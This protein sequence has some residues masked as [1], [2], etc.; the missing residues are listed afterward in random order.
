MS[1][2][3]DVLRQ[4][5]AL[6]AEDRAYVVTVLGR[7]LSS[8]DE[9]FNNDTD[10]PEDSVSG[11]AFLAELQRRSTAYRAGTATARPA[12]AVLAD[13]KVRQAREQST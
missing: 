8:E 5:M 12:A 7:S 1:H 6:P 4:A 11:D 10:I 3:E 2:R 13:L 9:V